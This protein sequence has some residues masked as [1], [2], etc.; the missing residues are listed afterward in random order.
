M[1]YVVRLRGWEL[2]NE[3]KMDEGKMDEGKMD[4]EMRYLFVI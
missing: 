3:W 2:W 4:E 1:M